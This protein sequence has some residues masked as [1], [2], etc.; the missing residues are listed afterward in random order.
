MI[1]YAFGELRL[2]RLVG[3]AHWDNA[4]SQNLQRR[5]GFRVEPNLRPGRRRW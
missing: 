5:L 1:G 2:R 4:C 3:G